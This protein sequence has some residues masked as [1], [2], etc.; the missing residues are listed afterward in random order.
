MVLSASHPDLLVGAKLVS[1][2]VHGE[3][4]N[5]KGQGILLRIKEKVIK[6]VTNKLEAGPVSFKPNW[7]GPRVGPGLLLEREIGA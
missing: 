2:E 6:D 4:G 5:P 3:M 7:S 1:P